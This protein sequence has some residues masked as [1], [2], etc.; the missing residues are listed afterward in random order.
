MPLSVTFDRFEYSLL[1]RGSRL[2]CT[3]KNLASSL[4]I[5]RK[6]LKLAIEVKTVP[7]A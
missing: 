2:F 3:T 6:K 4:S 1:V 5:L 7:S